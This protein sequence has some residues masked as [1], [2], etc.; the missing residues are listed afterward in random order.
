MCRLKS[1]TLATHGI[2]DAGILAIKQKANCKR[3]SADQAGKW[4][5]KW[6]EMDDILG[7]DPSSDIADI[8]LI[9]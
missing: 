1:L 9:K 2:V 8:G 5:G 7:W 4:S 3:N 6:R